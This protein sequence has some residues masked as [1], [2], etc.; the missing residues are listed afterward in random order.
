M[1]TIIGSLV[2]SFFI[3]I[4]IGQF[5]FI[6]D[7]PLV[8]PQFIAGIKNA[9]QTIASIPKNIFKSP[10]TASTNVPNI[11]AP[12]PQAS[13]FTK[14]FN[15]LAPGVYAREEGGVMYYRQEG[16]EQQTS[17]TTVTNSC[18]KTIKIVYPANNP[19]VKEMVE[20]IKGKC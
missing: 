12:T 10:D 11:P 7:T 6:G 1:L 2:L 14:S 17:E 8:N 9:P 5:I 20:I 15:R 18:G 16:S 3:V 13:M 19:P 4:G